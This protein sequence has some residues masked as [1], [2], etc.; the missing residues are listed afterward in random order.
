MSNVS[1]QFRTLTTEEELSFLKD[2]LPV[3]E[4]RITVHVTDGE[5]VREVWFDLTV[6]EPYVPPPPEPEEPFY[7]TS[8]GLGLIV[9]VVIG[10]VLV[11]AFLATRSRGEEGPEEE[12]TPPPDDGD[13]VMDV[14]EGSQRYEVAALGQELGRLADE[15][16][17]SKGTEEAVREPEPEALD[18]EDVVVPSAEELAEREHAGEVREVMK[19]LTQ[20]P[21]GLPSALIDYDLTKLALMITDGPRREGPD[22]TPLVE[23]DGKWY[24]ADHNK[25]STFLQVYDES[26]GSG[27]TPEDER[28]R[29]LEKLEERLL[30]GQISEETYERLRRKYEGG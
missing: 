2:D 8:S 1:G 23:I 15:L 9:A 12:T 24:T 20:L 28:A 30:D 18:L 17:A 4:H 7:Q 10:L 27:K 25:T 3:G 26:S 19:T 29:K 16:E 5:H 14:V 22:G 11:V 13:I 6:V 21:R